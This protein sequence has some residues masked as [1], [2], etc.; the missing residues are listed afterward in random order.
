MGR[1][2]ADG[3]MDTFFILSRTNLEKEEMNKRERCLR[4][5]RGGEG[6]R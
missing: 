5:R 6:R 3:W 4:G 2:E 1:T